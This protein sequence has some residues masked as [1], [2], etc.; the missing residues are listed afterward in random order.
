MIGRGHTYEQI[1]TAHP[2][3]TY[4]DIFNAARE[5]LAIGGTSLSY[6]EKVDAVKAMYPRAYEAWTAE[7]ES[8]LLELVAAGTRSVHSFSANSVPFRAG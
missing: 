3:F 4:H 5:A 2:S 8:R 1:L 6:H 7:E